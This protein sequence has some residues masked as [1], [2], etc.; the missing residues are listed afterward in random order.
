MMRSNPDVDASPIRRENPPGRASPTSCEN[1]LSSASPSR[2]E[3]P[4]SRASLTTSE[5]PASGAKLSLDEQIERAYCDNYMRR[6][7]EAEL[8][9]TNF[10]KA[11]RERKRQQGN[12]PLTQASLRGL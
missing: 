10:T 4:F 8:D 6:V 2:S 11:M 5:N 9:P 7:I 12:H 1:P 3:T